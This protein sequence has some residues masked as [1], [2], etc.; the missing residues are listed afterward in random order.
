MFLKVL[1]LSCLVLTSTY[2]SAQDRCC[3]IEGNKKISTFQQS[4]LIKNKE[5]SSLTAQVRIRA[6][7]ATNHLA[8]DEVAEREF[9]G[10]L[11]DISDQLNKLP[12]K[13][14]Q[15]ISTSDLN[16]PI[17]KKQSILVGQG[18]EVTLRFLNFENNKVCLWIRWD[19]ETGLKVLDTRMHFEAGQSM[20]VGTEHSEESGIVLAL[21]VKP[22]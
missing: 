9:N 21:D 4:S 8:K 18:N 7:K 19:D 22:Q 14:F 1:L 5:E 10:D 16:T 3:S 20:V 12:Y 13:S 6:I 11:N 15:V 17:R 2:A